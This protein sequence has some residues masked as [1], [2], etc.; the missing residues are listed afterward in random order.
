VQDGNGSTNILAFL[1]RSASEFAKKRKR[2]GP[3]QPLVSRRVSTMVDDWTEYLCVR[4]ARTPGEFQVAVCGTSRGGRLRPMQ[5]DSLRDI[6][7]RVPAAIADAL[8]SL[9]WPVED[10]STVQRALTV[11]AGGWPNRASKS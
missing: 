4:P 10:L 2:E 3:W 9:G 7:G 6:S 11:L 5:D 8:R 1:G